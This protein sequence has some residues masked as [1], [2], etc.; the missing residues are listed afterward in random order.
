MDLATSPDPNLKARSTALADA[1]S[2]MI[3]A[4]LEAKLS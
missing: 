1:S 2:M 3:Q 4:P